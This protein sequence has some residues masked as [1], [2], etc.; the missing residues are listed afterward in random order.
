MNALPTTNKVYSM[1]K[2][3][4]STTGGRG[5]NFGFGRSSYIGVIGN[6]NR[7]NYGNAGF[8]AR[9][10]YNNASRGNSVNRGGFTTGRAK[11]DVDK[12]S[13]YYDYCDVGHHARETCFRLNG[14]LDWYHNYKE[15]KD[16]GVDKPR[17]NLADT[18]LVIIDKADNNKYVPQSSI[19]NLIQ[20]ELI[21]LVKE[22]MIVDDHAVNFARLGEFAGTHATF[23]WMFRTRNLD[24]G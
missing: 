10:G 5:N 22:K 16:M 13:R 21:K 6:G 7:G 15:R 19:A 3:G 24:C 8:G 11:F 4:H 14:Y 18:P 2:H 20:Q 23:T 17:A 1:F 9:G 12:A